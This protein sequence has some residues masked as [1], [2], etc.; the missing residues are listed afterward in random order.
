MR[1]PALIAGWFDYFSNEQLGQLINVL[2]EFIQTEKETNMVLHCCQSLDRI[3]VTR[4]YVLNG[5]VIRKIFPIAINTFQNAE[6]PEIL[7]PMVNLISNI[8]IKC[9]FDSS[10]IM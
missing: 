4:K 10:I 1:I 9:E 6:N 2:L 7:W 5:E 3:I 8:I